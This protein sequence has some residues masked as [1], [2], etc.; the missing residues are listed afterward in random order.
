MRD[1]ITDVAG[2]KVGHASN[3][4]G[5]T[6]CTVVLCEEGAIGGI[7][8]RGSAPGTR[9]V[10]S[11]FPLHLVSKVH[12]V[13]LTGGS[14]FGLDAAGGVA[15]YLEER[16]KGF[17]V[18][19]THVPIVPTAVIFDLLFGD[20]ATRPNAD[21]G[22]EACMAASS[23]EVPEGSVGVGTGATIGKLYELSR[24]SKGGVGTASIT[25]PGGL[26]VGALVVVNA[27]GDVID[28]ETGA[29]MAGLRESETSV[30]LV[31]TADLLCQGAEKIHLGHAPV[32]NT[33][34]GVVATNALLTRE[35]AIKMAQMANNG[36]ARTISPISTSFDG[37]VVFSLSLGQVQVAADVNNAGMLAERAVIRAVRRA[38]VKAEG[39]GLLPAHKDL[40]PDT[41]SI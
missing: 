18:S 4:E 9:Q 35:E 17:D 38:I 39:F 20:H 14:S 33:T 12:A 2:I 7:D 8:I 11:L 21:M 5:Y 25:G 15:R 31:S 3:F 36:L 13:L 26:I 37:D 6:G 27:L 10:D 40:H 41:V 30:R 24:A 32:G 34:L 23:H 22:Y 16:G 1:V 29:L 28:S 19:V